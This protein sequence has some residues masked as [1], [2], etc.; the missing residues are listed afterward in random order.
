MDPKQKNMIE[1]QFCGL[2]VRPGYT[3]SDR[4]VHLDDLMSDC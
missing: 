4:A 1:T 2:V 3:F